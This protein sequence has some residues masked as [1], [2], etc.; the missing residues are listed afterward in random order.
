MPETIQNCWNHTPI[1]L[2]SHVAGGGLDPKSLVDLPS[3]LQ[4]MTPHADPLAWKIIHEFATTDLSLPNAK[5]HLQAHLSGHF[6]DADWKPALQAV[7]NAKGDHQAAL[8]AIKPLE[9]MAMCQPEL[10]IQISLYPKNLPQLES[11]QDELVQS[12]KDLK[13]QNHI[14]NTLPPWTMY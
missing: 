3:S 11:V 10:K 12:I 1:Q 8:I 4:S 7:M 2:E 13:A 6:I 5:I 9:E 14:F